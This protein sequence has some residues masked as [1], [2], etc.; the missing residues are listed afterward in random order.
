MRRYWAAK[1]AQAGKPAATAKISQ[2]KVRKWTDAEKKALSLKLKQAWKK[3][4]AAAA[5]KALKAPEQASK[6]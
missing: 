5:P 2:A 4:K 3:R 6:P 1:R